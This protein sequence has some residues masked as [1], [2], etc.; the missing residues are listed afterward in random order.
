LN[1]QSITT[2]TVYFIK[3]ILPILILS[4]IIISCHDNRDVKPGKDNA[5]I[6][7]SEVPLN[8]SY[9]D[10]V[11]KVIFYL[12]NSESMFGY[13][14]GLT[15]Y[16]DVVSELSEKPL[17]VAE[18]TK[19][20]FYFINGG[21][22]SINR[23]GDNPSNLKSKLNKAGFNCGDISKS[24]L[25]AMFQIAL[26]KAQNDTIALLISDGIYDVDQHDTPLNALAILGKET[27]SKFI[28]RIQNGDIQTLLIKLNSKFDGKYFFSSKRGS[29][30]ITQSRPFYIWIFGKSKLVNKY[31]PE[32]YISKQ[33][34]GYDNYVR[35]LKI[36]TGTVPYQVSPSLNVKGSFRPDRRSATGLTDA[37]VGRHGEGFQFSIA[38]DFSGLPFSETYLTDVS[39]YSANNNY[40]IIDI[41]PI[42]QKEKNDIALKN[43]T[44]VI[45]VST[46]K[47]PYGVL[48]IELKNKIPNWIGETGTDNENEI[49]TAHTYGFKFLTK[50]ISDAYDYENAEKDLA[51][52]KIEISK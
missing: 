10:T 38:A 6:D 40:R 24:N 16:V 14:T 3:T 13:V 17:F 12:E 2:S 51:T 23:I 9:K 43:P 26:Q 34:K 30:K 48:E 31:F 39:N 27:R 47:S 46:K 35:F 5:D 41:E 19:R 29:I 36:K 4:I 37:K 52:I 11:G 8:I 42:K 21:I 49:D 45:T 15:Q 18:N 1:R 25:N 50:A 7:N 33:L 28:E 32:E 22:L 44:H 20:E